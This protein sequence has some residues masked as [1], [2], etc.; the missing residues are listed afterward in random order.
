MNR[1]GIWNGSFLERIPT[2]TENASASI[3]DKL[4]NLNVHRLVGYL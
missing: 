1:T 3:A 4:L 2:M